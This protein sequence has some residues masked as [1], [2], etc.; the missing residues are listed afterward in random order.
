MYSC[1]SLRAGDV[2]KSI[3][4][5]DGD[6]IEWELYQIITKTPLDSPLVLV[7]S[8]FKLSCKYIYHVLLTSGYSE[9]KLVR[10]K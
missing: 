9:Q 6:E 5:A 1:N 8:G 2:S 10:S 4:K 3:L 7:T